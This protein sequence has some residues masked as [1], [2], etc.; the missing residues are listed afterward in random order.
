MEL[1]SNEET[2]TM[3]TSDFKQ[4][5]ADEV[6]R[7]LNQEA[8]VYTPQNVFNSVAIRCVDIAIINNQSRIASNW[9]EKQGENK[10]GMYKGA[11]YSQNFF[12]TSEWGK[13]YKATDTT[14]HELLRKLAVTV[15]GHTTNGDIRFDEFELAQTY[16]NEFKN[17]WLGLYKQRLSD[18][19]ENK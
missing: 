2:I 14:V 3:S 15:L 10:G 12:N 4:L 9:I 17:V 19:E 8:K 1:K 16:Y 11:I 7:T 18:M 6:K 13:T 5:I